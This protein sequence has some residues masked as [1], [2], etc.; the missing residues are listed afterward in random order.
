[1]VS[2]ASEKC[3]R[4]NYSHK[5]PY[6]GLILLADFLK[7]WWGRRIARAPQS[8][9]SH[10]EDSG[11]FSRAVRSSQHPFSLTEFP[12]SLLQR[13]HYI[14]W[15]VVSFQKSSCPASLQDMITKSSFP[16]TLSLSSIHTFHKAWFMSISSI[17]SQDYPCKGIS[18]SRILTC[19]TEAISSWF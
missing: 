14:V 5:F 1:M 12:T 17:S 15:A 19:G 11:S 2:Q 3:N 8:G 10:S 9:T 18:L 13:L 7:I 16:F 6:L 4:W